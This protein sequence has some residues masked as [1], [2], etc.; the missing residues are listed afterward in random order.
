MSTELKVDVSVE[1]LKKVLEEME[2]MWWQIDSEW[3]PLPGGL[4]TAVADGK[5]PLIEELRR[6]IGGEL[7]RT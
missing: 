7:K 6:I 2:G 3:G 1:F 5:E 4:E